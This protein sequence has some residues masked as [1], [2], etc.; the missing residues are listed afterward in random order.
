MLSRVIHLLVKGLPLENFCWIVY[1]LHVLSYSV[2][3][4]QKTLVVS[5]W[6]VLANVG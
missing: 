1:K 5:N 2:K 3:N 4:I 6:G